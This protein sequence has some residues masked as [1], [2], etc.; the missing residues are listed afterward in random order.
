M[1]LG[2]A[3]L[4]MRKSGRDRIRSK[5]RFKMRKWTYNVRGYDSDLA[6]NLMPI[7]V[8]GANR[9]GTSLCSYIIG[10]HPRVE[11]I[12]T[13]QE[14]PRI[15]M[16][17]HVSGYG[18]SGHIWHSLFDPKYDDTKGEGLL[19]GLPSFIS[20]V[21]VDAVSEAQKRHLIS[22]LLSARTTDNIPVV[23]LNHNALRIPL[24]KRLF[25]KARFVLITRDHKSHIESYKHKWTVDK[26]KGL[27]SPY[28]EIDYPHV[29]LHWLLI[30][31]V[32]L[33]DLRKYAENDYIHIKLEDLHA[34]KPVRD[35]TIS[36]VFGFLD[37]EPIEV[38][39]DFF[40]DSYIY[41]RSSNET[42]ID[43]IGRMVDDLIDFETSLP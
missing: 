24:I 25:P 18:E 36:R 8:I 26:E 28:S 19:F 1:L 21:Y 31:T 33:Y 37:L 20:K 23:K 41:K 12:F 27:V 10:M 39:D 34:E 9:S 30:N 35:A 3:K 22:E 43:I 13:E 14:G 4:I 38:S 11:G 40:D 7:F 15:R 2:K 16:N 5:I 29:G 6:Q 32:A 17:G 42:D